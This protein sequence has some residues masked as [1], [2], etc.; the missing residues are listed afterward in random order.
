VRRREFIAGLAGSATVLPLAAWAQQPTALLVGYLY[1]GSP[2]PVANYLAEFRKGL[3]QMG[4][5]EGRNLAIEFRFAHNE[6]SRLPEL[7]A[8]LVSRRVNVIAAPGNAAGRNGG[9]KRYSNH[10]DRFQQRF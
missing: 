3:S 5:V 8:E 10:S 7:A 1:A 2:E 6:I 4:F 9:Q